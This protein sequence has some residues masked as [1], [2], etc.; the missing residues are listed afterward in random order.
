MG[1]ISI[2]NDQPFKIE[3]H[4]QIKKLVEEKRRVTVVELSTLLNVSEAT[5]RR[6]LEELDGQWLRRIHGGAIRLERAAKEPPMMERVAEQEDEKKRIGRAAA[7]LAQE[8]ETIFLG[9]GTTTMEIVHH[10]PEA[11][12]LT[13]ITNSLPVVNALAGRP[14]IELIVIG[15]MFRP[16]ELSMVGHIAEHAIREF[17]ADRVFMG[18]R[19]IDAKHGFTNDFLPE[20]TTDRTLMSIAPQV[21][22]VADHTKF[23]LVSSVF[24]APIT[25]A[26]LIITDTDTPSE[27]VAELRELGAEVLLA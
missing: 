14:N 18:M 10:L 3:R 22:V 5:V 4:S 23:G 26:H 8:G 21:V 7:Q 17:R 15:G 20:T 27:I 2:A 25:A 13:A 6:D 9:S 16:S 19:A 12:R 24:V 1:Q 11:I